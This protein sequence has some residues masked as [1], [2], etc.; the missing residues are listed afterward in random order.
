MNVMEFFNWNI[1]GMHMIRTCQAF[2]LN[3]IY[4]ICG[5]NNVGVSNSCTIVEAKLKIAKTIIVFVTW[6]VTMK[7]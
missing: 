4:D 1:N 7:Y 5:S 3:D 6:L 2:F